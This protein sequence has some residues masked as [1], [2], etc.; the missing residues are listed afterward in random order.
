MLR[1]LR[2]CYNLSN[3]TTSYGFVLRAQPRTNQLPN[4]SLHVKKEFTWACGLWFGTV[5]FFPP[6]DTKTNQIQ[7]KQE[8]NRSD[9]FF[10]LGSKKAPLGD[11]NRVCEWLGLEAADVYVQLI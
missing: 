4:G 11:R 7:G 5:V 6:A 10:S 9:M 1:L 3:S 8:L 2:L